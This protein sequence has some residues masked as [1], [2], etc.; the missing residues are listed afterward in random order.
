MSDNFGRMSFA[1][2]RGKGRGHLSDCAGAGKE[3][4]GVGVAVGRGSVEARVFFVEEIH[5]RYG[6]CNII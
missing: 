2:V 4:A 3:G 5:V 1:V 6:L